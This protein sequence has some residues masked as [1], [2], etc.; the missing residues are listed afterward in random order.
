MLHWSDRVLHFLFLIFKVNDRACIPFHVCTL[1]IFF[2]ESRFLMLMWLLPKWNRDKVQIGIRWNSHGLP[3]PKTIWVLTYLYFSE[4]WRLQ[5]SKMNLLTNLPGNLSTKC[6]QKRKYSEWNR[7]YWKPF[8]PTINPHKQK[9]TQAQ[10]V[11][12]QL[13]SQVSVALPSFQISSINTRCTIR[14]HAH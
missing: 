3:L 11:A 2:W 9:A 1:F 13:C 7:R 8:L 6:S 12:H 5:F 10:R 4:N 14:I